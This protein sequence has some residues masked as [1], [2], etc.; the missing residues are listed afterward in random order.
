MT[1]AQWSQSRLIRF[2]RSSTIPAIKIQAP[3]TGTTALAN[4]NPAK[5]VIPKGPKIILAD[6]RTDSAIPRNENAKK[7]RQNRHDRRELIAKTSK[8]K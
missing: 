3:T 8:M 4:V 2:F 7:A 6:V 5:K 1:P